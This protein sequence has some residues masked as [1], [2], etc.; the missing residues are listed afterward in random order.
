MLQ[1]HN[2]DPR[3]HP[4]SR[5]PMNIKQQYNETSKRISMSKKVVR[6]GIVFAHKNEKWW[7]GGPLPVK[8]LGSAVCILSDVTLCVSHWL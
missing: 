5:S 3:L 7:G 2:R 1:F 6:Q 8:T 4:K